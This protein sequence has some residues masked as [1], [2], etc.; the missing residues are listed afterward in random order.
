VE[1]SVAVRP[2]AEWLQEALVALGERERALSAEGVFKE[3]FPE[4][5]YGK[6]G[7]R[8]VGVNGQPH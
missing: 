2:E 7:E 4:L 8:G 1:P 5:D 6:V 3:A